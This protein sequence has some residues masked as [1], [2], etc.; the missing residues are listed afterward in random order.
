MSAFTSAKCYRAGGEPPV[1]TAPELALFVERVL[2]LDIL[3]SS[4]MIIELKFGQAIDQDDI[5]TMPMQKVS[6]LMTLMLKYG[7]DIE[8]FNIPTTKTLEILLHPSA[9]HEVK[10][11]RK[12][13]RDSIGAKRISKTFA[14]N[15]YRAY[16][17]FGSLKK[18]VYNPIC[19]GPEEENPL[20]L[21]ELA[22]SIDMVEL[23]DPEE[24][25]AFQVGYL[26][27]SVS[28]HGYLFP[29]T[30]EETLEKLRANLQLQQVREICRAMWPAKTTPPS[31]EIMEGRRRMGKLWAEPVD[32]SFDWYWA[33]NE[34][35]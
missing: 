3:Q 33:I 31:P 12:H 26:C 15:I 34:T 24:S 1:I 10:R 16:L 23:N 4:N 18:E 30:Y 13:R 11:K 2:A 6:P 5:D 8:Q 27:F 19:H 21:S 20:W 29:W 28:G 32:A 7:W 14:P 9:S 17:D 25:E 22:F 35:Y